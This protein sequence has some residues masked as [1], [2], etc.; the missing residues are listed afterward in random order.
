MLL[1]QV[2]LVKL[3]TVRKL[4]T[5]SCDFTSGLR[6]SS[7][8]AH[9]CSSNGIS[10]A[11][12]LSWHC[13]GIAVAMPWHGHGDVR[14][15]G[16]SIACHVL[17]PLAPR[18]GC[19]GQIFVNVIGSDVCEAFFHIIPI[20]WARYLCSAVL[21][22]RFAL[23]CMCVTLAS[24]CL[25]TFYIC[26]RWVVLVLRYLCTGFTFV[27]DWSWQCHDNGMRPPWPVSSPWR[28]MTFPW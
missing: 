4:R 25:H 9:S 7:S 11:T 17:V 20:P 27:S 24:Y 10:D 14:F 3:S 18:R 12:A 5:T 19:A 13:R 15:H 23:L 16:I 2:A 28:A 26:L 6:P 22:I 21:C 1:S 8:D